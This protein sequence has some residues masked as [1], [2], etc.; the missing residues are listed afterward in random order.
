M[1]MAIDHGA[2][3]VFCDIKTPPFKSK[4]ELIEVKIV[5]PSRWTSE[6]LERLEAFLDEF[7]EEKGAGRTRVTEEG[8]GT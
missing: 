5:L 2:I 1:D 8:T 3:A 6:L 7:G 4:S